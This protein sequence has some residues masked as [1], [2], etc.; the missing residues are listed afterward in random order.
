MAGG[1]L[2]VA[3]ILSLAQGE[4]GYAV[5]LAAEARRARL[6][7]GGDVSF[8]NQLDVAPQLRLEYRA[9]AASVSAEYQPHLWYDGATDTTNLLHRAVLGLTV[10]PDRA[11][12]LRGAFS[13]GYGYQDVL[14]PAASGSTQPGQPQPVQPVAR[15]SRLYQESG[16]AM[17]V[18]E[19]QATRTLQLALGG[20]FVASGGANE[21][22]RAVAPLTYGP[23]ATLA[24][25]WQAT[26]RDSLATDLSYD[27]RF[28]E[29]SRAAAAASPPPVWYA[30]ATEVWTH[31]ISPTLSARAGVGGAVTNH[32]WEPSPAGEAALTYAH[33][34]G[35]SVRGGGRYSPS[36]DPLTARVY[37][38]ADGSL[39]L[40]GP[41][42]PWLGLSLEAAG[43]RVTSGPQQGQVT[44]RGE[45]RASLP[46]GAL[47]VSPGL[48]VLL[49][50][51]PS[52]GGGAGAADFTLW[53]GTLTVAWGRR[54]D[55]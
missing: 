21:A 20:G 49:Q 30:V 26:A 53:T 46:W 15:V 36:I 11:L 16:D 34:S 48:R 18:A 19:I 25:A 2:L 4:V 3:A 45:L 40:S 47:T 33:R 51:A 37:S 42:A 41:A 44:F 10:T 9:A 7:S 22:A 54:G 31:A 12:R 55:L 52:G 1:A 5:G 8:Q 29:V 27:R 24:L 23:R 17:V 50:H 35:W 28:F 38:L 32:S 39:S 13:G 6:D 14:T 43:G